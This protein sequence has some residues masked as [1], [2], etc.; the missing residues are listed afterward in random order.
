ML[1]SKTTDC[2][3]SIMPQEYFYVFSWEYA[4]NL[5]K[6][7]NSINIRQFMSAYSVHFYGNYIK[8]YNVSLNLGDYNIHEFFASLF[9][10]VTYDLLKRNKIE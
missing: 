1:E 10:P 8:I 6:Q 7:N 4:E 3:V 2:D 5:F 9:C